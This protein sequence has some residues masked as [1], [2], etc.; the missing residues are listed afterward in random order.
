MT[1]DL[2]LA[3]IVSEEV[4]ATE[5]VYSLSSG[6][7]VEAATYGAGG[8]VRGVVVR[9][10]EVEV[11]IVARYQPDRAIPELTNTL[12]ERVAPKTEGRKVAVVVE[13]IEVGDSANL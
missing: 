1:N 2:E 3:R 9:P 8:T 5:G 10:E 7:F 4:L 11:H 6:K 13:D 12:I